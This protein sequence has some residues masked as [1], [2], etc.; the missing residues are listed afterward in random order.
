[1]P[2]VRRVLRADALDAK[3]QLHTENGMTTPLGQHLIAE[4][5]GAANLLEPG[6]VLPV[7]RAAAQAAGATVLEVRS[8]DFGLRDGF[9]AVAMLAE[10]HI[11]VHTW[12]ELGYAAIDIF[13]CGEA[14][15]RDSLP[16]LLA[17]FEPTRHQ[18]RVIPRGERLTV[19]A[20]PA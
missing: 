11:S 13:M 14:D 19:V 10:S 15:P 7:L 6:A 18:I 4:F 1:M 8:H 20:D 16:A 3:V 17:H 2:M 5:H 12:P 9:T